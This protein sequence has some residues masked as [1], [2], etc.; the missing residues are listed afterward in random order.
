[1]DAAGRQ[2]LGE[3]DFA[4][5]RGAYAEPVR[6]TVRRV[7]ESAVHAAPPLLVYRI[8][9]TAFLKL[10]VRNIVGTLVEVG[11]GERAADSLGALLA[12]RDRTSAGATAPAHGLMLVA[13][14]Y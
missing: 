14:R 2:L 1:M 13:V 5:F 6:S 7:L 10:M 4:A 8:E 9:A 12:G 3:H 11:R